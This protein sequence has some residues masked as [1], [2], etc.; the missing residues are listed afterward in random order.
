MKNVKLKQ[1][2]SKT[3]CKITSISRL[4][5]YALK[6]LNLKRILDYLAQVA[7]NEDQEKFHQIEK[8][9]KDMTAKSET[10]NSMLRKKKHRQNDRIDAKNF[11]ITFNCDE[12]YIKSMIDCWN[13]FDKEEIRE[14]TSFGGQTTI[15]IKC[16]KQKSL[17]LSNK[18]LQIGNY[19]PIEIETMKNSA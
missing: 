11:K 13:Y 12:S 2:N 18:K 5:T 9:L 3:K 1:R 8:N 6:N 15:E 19:P 10:P 7:E 17:H 16:K 14:I 4:E